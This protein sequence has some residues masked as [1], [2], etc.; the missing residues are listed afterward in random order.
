MGNQLVSK[1]TEKQKGITGG[2]I[3][4]LALKNI[5][6]QVPRGIQSLEGQKLVSQDLKDLYNTEIAPIKY[7]EKQR[8]LEETGGIYPRNLDQ[9]AE[10]RAR[11]IRDQ[12]VAEINA[13]HG[14]S[15]TLNS[16]PSASKEEV[17]TQ[18]RASDGKIY[19]VGKD[20][21]YFIVKGK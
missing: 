19:E 7:E 13:K 18:F 10:K 20:H 14:G 5:I 17:G 15:E 9:L 12:R 1:I 3:T 2:R 11:V 8:I 16:L 4:D 6:G 21:K